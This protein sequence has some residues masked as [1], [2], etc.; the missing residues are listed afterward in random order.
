[1]ELK[2]YL[3]VLL[4]WWWLS[5]IAFLT[6]LTASIAFTYTQTPK[7]EATASL[8]VSPTTA[9]ADLNEVRASLSA[10]DKPTVIN[11]YA[12][13][14]QSQTIVQQAWDDLAVPPETRWRFEGRSWV[15][16]KT[17][18]V[19]I[20][21]AGPDPAIVHEAANAIARHTVDY[22]GELYEVYDLKLLDAAERPGSPVSPNKK[23]NI[24]MGFVLGGGIGIA[25]TFVAEYLRAPMEKIEQLSLINAQTGAYKRSYFLRRLREEV[26]RSRRHQRPFAISRMRVDNLDEIAENYPPR[27]R[28]LALQQVVHFLRQSLPEEDVI[29]HWDDDDLV[30][31]LPDCDEAMARQAVERLHTK[32]QWTLFDV[33][34]LGF[35]LNLTASFGLATYIC[36]GVGPDDLLRK[37]T[38][39]LHRAEIGG[40]GV[41][42]L[43]DE[44]DG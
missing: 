15:L 9:L 19:L 2:R 20:T 35:K 24:L 29:A 17:N 14:A 7:Y 12:E 16:Q 3:K 6:V 33:E 32:M 26:S 44:A 5:L 40:N 1:M 36:N 4:R 38:E 37:A 27:T 25:F 22:V 30:I 31:L 18:I 23:L 13:I 42:R 10:L 41:H 21:V 39:A 8:V 11:T 34:D 43:K 28:E